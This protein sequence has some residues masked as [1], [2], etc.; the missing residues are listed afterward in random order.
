MAILL[1]VHFIG[2]IAWIGGLYTLITI[3]LN[4]AGSK[5]LENRNSSFIKEF[6][7]IGI[8]L[9]AGMSTASGLLLLYLSYGLLLSEG[10]FKL[11]C[12]FFLIALGLTGYLHLRL[13][14]S[15]SQKKVQK[16]LRTLRAIFLTLMAAIILLSF[17]RPF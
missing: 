12:F 11:K 15:I 16:R 2:L 9:G 5:D 17:L 7:F 1:S 13:K 4:I 6:T 3:L 10:W 8:Y 14:P